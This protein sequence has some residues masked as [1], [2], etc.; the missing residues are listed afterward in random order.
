[1][2][3]DDVFDR[4]CAKMDLERDVAELGYKFEGQLKGDLCNEL[5]T[6]DDLDDLFK[7]AIHKEERKRTKD[8]EVNIYNLVR[9]LLMS[10]PLN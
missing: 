5:S 6:A 3:F 4:A 2:P 1:M 10:C 7:K 9:V 8:V